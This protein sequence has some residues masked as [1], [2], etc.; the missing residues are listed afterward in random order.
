MWKKDVFFVLSKENFSLQT[1]RSNWKRWFSSNTSFLLASIFWLISDALSMQHMYVPVPNRFFPFLIRSR[2]DLS[3]CLWRSVGRSHARVSLGGIPRSKLSKIFNYAYSTAPKPQSKDGFNG[4]AGT[5]IAG[6]GYGLPIAR[7]YARYFHGNLAIASIE[8]F[9]TSAY[10]TLKVMRRIEFIFLFWSFD[11][12]S[13]P[14]LKMLGKL[15]DR[16]IARSFICFLLSLSRLASFCRFS[17][18]RGTLTR[19]T[20]APIGRFN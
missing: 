19:Q 13:R 5:T 14:P 17:A 1:A 15:L 8:D 4:S 20:K 7:L 16:S 3:V 18:H 6:L 10:V 12:F 11:V 2:V 9:G